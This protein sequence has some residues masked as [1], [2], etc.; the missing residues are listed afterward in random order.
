MLQQTKS[1]FLSILSLILLA[2][3]LSSAGAAAHVLRTYRRGNHFCATP[4]NGAIELSFVAVIFASRLFYP[5]RLLL[6]RKNVA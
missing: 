1:V 6:K 3:A 4:V 2:G 5:L